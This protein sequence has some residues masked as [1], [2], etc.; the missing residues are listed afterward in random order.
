MAFDSAETFLKLG[1]K[2]ENVMTFSQKILDLNPNG[3]AVTLNL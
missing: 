2:W 3:S 1:Y